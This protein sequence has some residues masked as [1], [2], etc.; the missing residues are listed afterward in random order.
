MRIDD[1]EKDLKI[2]RKAI[3]TSSRYTNITA[4][5]YFFSGLVAVI[6]TW[7]TYTLLGAEKVANMRLITSNDVKGLTL[8]WTLVL[9]I[10]LAIATFFSWR[11]ALQNKTSAWNSLTA[12]MFFSQIPLIALAG[13][14]TVGL[15]LKG[16]YEIVP[17]IWLGAYGVIFYSFSYFTGIG[18][19]IEGLV[20][21]GLASVAMFAPGHVVLLCL[22]LGFGGVHIAS[23]LARW[24][25][26]GMNRNES[27]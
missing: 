3:E 9:L 5:G 10:S 13:I 1:V 27:E 18:H 2:I 24:A 22:G 15:A 14:F 4:R 6:G 17:S 7:R 21:V 12:R 11:K 26:R 19:K 16:Y 20:F 25:A 8:I 23:A